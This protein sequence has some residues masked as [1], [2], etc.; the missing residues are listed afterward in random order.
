MGVPH[1]ILNLILGW[2]RER[3][4]KHKPFWRDRPSIGSG[5][6]HVR[7]FCSPY[8][9]GEEEKQHKAMISI[10]TTHVVLLVLC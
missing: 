8:S 6:K 9:C 5:S 4:T 1:P 10:A 7:V 3:P 2:G